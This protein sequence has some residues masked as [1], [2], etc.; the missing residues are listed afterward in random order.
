M[1]TIFPMNWKHV[2]DQSRTEAIRH[3]N[4]VVTPEHMLMAIMSQSGSHAF[5]AIQQL[6]D[7]DTMYQLRDTLDRS[8]FQGTGG[9]SNI[10]V[11]DLANRIIK[12]SVLEAKMLKSEIVDS[13]HLLLALFHNKEGTGN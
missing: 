7:A 13:E 10:S 5:Q 11:S 9:V 1:D 4:N 6:I 2:L 12:L 3:N 8:L